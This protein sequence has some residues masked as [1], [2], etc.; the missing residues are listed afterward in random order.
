MTQTSV[1]QLGAGD[2]LASA[3]VFIER[4]D[5]AQAETL[6]LSIINEG[7]EEVSSGR[8]VQ[9]RAALAEIY[10]GMG[11]YNDA[12]NVLAPYDPHNLD[13]QSPH[14]RGLL[15]LAF[16]S[17]AYWQNDFPRSVT[18]LNRA[19]EILEPV[20][21]AANIARAFH[22]L[23]RSYWAL[24]EQALAREHYEIAIEWGRRARKDR[25]LAITYMNLGLVARHEGDMDEAGMCYRRALRLLRH[26]TDEISR[27]RLQ[28]NLG[29]MLLYQGNFYE[30]ANSSRR[31]LEHLSGH[32]DGLLIG[33]V[34]NNL[35]VTCIHTGEWAQA[36]SYVQQALGIARARADRLSEGVYTETLGSLRAYQ[37]RMEEAN[38]LLRF[39]LERAR[40]MG[41]KK[42]EMLAFLSLSR[43]WLSARNVHLSLTYARNAR[44]LAREVGDER[45]ACE[46]ALLMAEGYRR[47]DKWMP[48]ED[49]ATMAKAELEHLPYPYLDAILQRNT[50]CFVSRRRDPALGDRIFR[51]AEESFRSMNAAFQTAVTIFEHGES[52]VR[53][54]EYAT[55]FERFTEA[56]AQFQKLG[57][58]LDA[59]RAERE[60][61]HTAER[62]GAWQVA[63][64]PS[65][66]L[67]PPDAAPLVMQVLNAASGR[68]RLLRELM[69]A[70]KNAL[71]AEGAIIF[72]ADDDEQL[73][74]QASIGLDE[75][76]REQAAKVVAQH[77]E[78]KEPHEQHESPSLGLQ[79]KSSNSISG[80]CRTL[81]SRRN[82]GAFVLYLKVSGSISGKRAEILDALVGCA[83]L[84]L[85]MIDMRADARRAR[86]FNAANM[87]R[88]TSLFPGLIATSSAMRDVLARMERLK[89]SDATVLVLGESGTGK[90]VVARALHEES[91]RRD[92]TFLPFNCSAAPRELV[93]S[94]L[95]G[96]RRGTFTG[97]INDQR[98]IIRA[99]EGGSL[100]L[101]EI[102]DLA[103]EVQPKLLRFLQNGEIMPLGEAPRKVNVRVIAATNRD[104][105]EDVRAGRF[106][107]DLFYRL[108]T[109][110]IKLPRLSE[111]PE[112]IPLLAMHF[113]DEMC[114]KHNRQLA[115]ITP[116]AMDYLTR[117]SWP[118]NVRQLRSEIERI[119]VFAED[120]QGVGA[121]SLS[122][123]ILR[124]AS[125]SSPVRFQLDFSRPINYKEIMLDIERQLLSEAL[126]RHS[127]NVTR[128]ADLLNMRRQTLDYKLRKFRLGNPH[129]NLV[130]DEEHDTEE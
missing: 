71:S 29:V 90:E 63:P 45:I 53:R 9:A 83:R 89:D 82:G 11:R 35:A 115:G 62:M 103:P 18:L 64:S 10:E 112:D 41:S 70:A 43:L 91:Q 55:A 42:D 37:G 17:R 105:E 21:D 6:L 31:A 88:A 116:E 59:E 106:R 46:S 26:T 34:N 76:D 126:A 75:R 1:N 114:R 100:F 65:I 94:Q 108:N 79:A 49:W 97:A 24:D 68:E 30:A 124:A 60:A 130:G 81:A 113:F 16:G 36:E 38:E 25:A 86:P 93:E 44:D 5:L 8:I 123:D 54:G 99:A 107:E 2:L 72:A 92:R 50:A 32:H 3:Q 56:A 19:R 28:N 120:G 77:L 40:E 12:G 125:V 23:G 111:R 13:Q 4:G 27:A 61:Q 48:A 33:I 57:A 129:I 73:Y 74:A 122:S 78:N 117:Y 85:Q 109:F 87:P 80:H 7:A 95:F 84:A 96:H 51:Q 15:L 104:L 14:L 121:E 127:G 67:I 119:V 39:A 22:C 118:G 101:D 20:G 52:L 102:G 128:T 58:R 69:F 66:N 110:V 47:S 98:G